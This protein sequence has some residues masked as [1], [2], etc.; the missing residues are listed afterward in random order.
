MS[1][2]LG[3]VLKG[4]TVD[5]RWSR[6]YS[7]FQSWWDCV[8]NNSKLNKKKSVESVHNV[9]GEFCVCEYHVALKCSQFVR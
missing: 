5:R 3:E 6:I 1:G 9:G 4:N 7:I 2:I 8:W